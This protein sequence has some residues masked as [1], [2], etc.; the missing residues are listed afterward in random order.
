MR[1]RRIMT[2]PTIRVRLAEIE[3]RAGLLIPTG[4]AEP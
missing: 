2:D 3:A 4:W 1:I